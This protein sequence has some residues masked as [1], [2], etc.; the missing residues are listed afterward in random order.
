MMKALL[1][2]GPRITSDTFAASESVPFDLKEMNFT[3]YA[4]NQ[5]PNSLSGLILPKA[6]LWQESTNRYMLK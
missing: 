5:I 1:I 3:D 4:S 6:R 2:P